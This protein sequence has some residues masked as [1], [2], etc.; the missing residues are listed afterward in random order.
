MRLSSSDHINGFSGLGQ[1]HTLSEDNK[2]EVQ[3]LIARTNA[4]QAG[5]PP[6][7]LMTPSDMLNTQQVLFL[8]LMCQ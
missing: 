5:N 8:T 1:Q 7:N 6:P 3:R 2:E 4:T